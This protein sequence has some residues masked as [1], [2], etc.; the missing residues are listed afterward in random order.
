MSAKG[1][2]DRPAHQC[3]FFSSA[4]NRA[5]TL[6]ASEGK[7]NA[8]FIAPHTLSRQITRKKSPDWLTKLLAFSARSAILAR[9]Q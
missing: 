1:A 8:P 2:Q 7:Q 3:S 6:P 5:L 9:S 4:R